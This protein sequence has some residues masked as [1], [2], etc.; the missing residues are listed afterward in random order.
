MSNEQAFQ[1]LV[2]SLKEHF[3]AVEGE[4]AQMRERLDHIDVVV[5]EAAEIAP[6]AAPEPER[7]AADV[8]VL[9]AV[10]PLPEE[11]VVEVEQVE[12]EPVAVCSAC[13]S[14]LQPSAR[15]CVICGEPIASSASVE[16]ESQSAPEP[17]VLVA[18]VPEP[19]P[20][21]AG[22]T[23]LERW[24]GDLSWGEF[25][26]R[27]VLVWVAGVVIV[28]GMILLYRRAVEAGWVGAA[29]RVALGGAVSFGM[30]GLAM[31]LRNRWSSE[32]GALVAAGVSI[33]GL[34][35]TLFAAVR[36]YELIGSAAGLPFAFAIAALAV[37]IALRW[38]SQPMAM[39]GLAGASLAP[40]LVSQTVTPL[41]AAFVVIVAAAG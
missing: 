17:A 7:P 27:R 39:L 26:G 8:A 29:G 34:Y 37:V 25:F 23:L 6:I 2:D 40:P 13:G 35:A 22:P 11:A 1:E 33:A 21:P 20:V 31:L 32:E 24:R 28:I 41:S 19:E 14:A 12:P 9:A 18:P 4:M 3:A 38:S 36:M 30:L 16:Q 15:F 5:H 10:V